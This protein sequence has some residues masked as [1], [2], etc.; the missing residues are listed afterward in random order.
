ME[1]T[2]SEATDWVSNI[3][4]ANWL[5]RQSVAQTSERATDAPTHE[6]A[7]KG[8]TSGLGTFLAIFGVLGVMGVWRLVS[9]NDESV[10][11]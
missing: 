2:R 10:S 3:L 7:A 6:A 11:P 8:M 9:R 5:E 4:K 1:W